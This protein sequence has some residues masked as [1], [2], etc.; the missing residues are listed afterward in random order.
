M[1]LSISATS[2][3]TLPIHAVAQFFQHRARHNY[4]QLNIFHQQDVQGRQ[5]H[6]VIFKAILYLF[7]H[8]RGMDR[9]RE[10]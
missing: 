8:R 2:F 10:G 4:V 9:Q 5:R 3:S 7:R 6:I 1:I